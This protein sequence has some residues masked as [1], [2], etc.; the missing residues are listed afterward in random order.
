MVDDDGVLV[1]KIISGS[2]L[3]L[4]SFIFGVVP[5]K[6]AQLFKWS[7]SLNPDN[8]ADNKIS[9]RIVSALLCFGGG[10]LLATTFLHLL[11]CNKLILIN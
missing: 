2:V 5:V 3:F 10:I 11:P 7:E 1:A 4:L 6:L 8:T 9:S